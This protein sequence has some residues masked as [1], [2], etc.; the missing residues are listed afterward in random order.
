MLKTAT[1]LSFSTKI[2]GWSPWTR[3]PML[4]FRRAKTFS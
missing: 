2:W 1:A 3:S 4:G